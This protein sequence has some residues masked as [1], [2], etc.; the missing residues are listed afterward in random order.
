M[1]ANCV[2]SQASQQLSENV[3]HLLAVQPAC[4]SGMPRSLCFPFYLLSSP[5]VKAQDALGEPVSAL[6]NLLPGSVVQ[7][8][9]CN[10]GGFHIHE[11]AG[12]EQQ[13]KDGVFSGSFTH[14]SA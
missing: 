4:F 8:P 7:N 11:G 12:E 3:S 13:A 6:L 2:G 9:K 10:W 5:C 1:F 14:P